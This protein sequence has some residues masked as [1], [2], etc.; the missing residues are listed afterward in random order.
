MGVKFNRE[1]ED[2]VK[3]M[4]EAIVAIDDFYTF[5]DMSEKDWRGLDQEERVE[6]A[7]TLA[8]DLFYSLG[9][10]PEIEIGTAKLQYDA[11][12]HILKMVY[13]PKHTKIIHLI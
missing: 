1:Y 3:D 11:S 2:I 13:D 9:A 8:D 6:C 7:K 5:F 4:V 10:D 12:H